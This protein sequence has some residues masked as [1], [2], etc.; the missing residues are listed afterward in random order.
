MSPRGDPPN[1]SNERPANSSVY[2]F[3]SASRL[4]RHRIMSALPFFTAI[5]DKL[6]HLRL[7]VKRNLGQMTKSGRTPGLY[8]SG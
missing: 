4:Q 6:W 1:E 7:S 8:R 2:R 5:P 3:R